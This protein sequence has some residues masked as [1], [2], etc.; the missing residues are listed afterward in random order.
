MEINGLPLHPLVVHAV[1]VLV[2]TTALVGLAYALVPRWRWLLRWPLLAVSVVAAGASVLAASSGQ[3]LVESRP[4]LEALV[5]QHRSYG[6]QL[7]NLA[8][9]YVAATALGAWV[10]GG[11]SALA[12]GAGARE[13]R[14]SALGWLA[15]TL[16]VAGGVAL[17]VVAFLAGESGARAVW[18][19]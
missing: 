15:V 2:P 7:R 13:T 1:V 12:S 8:L 9:A 11:T 6:Q 18:G 16:L 17:L 10:L 14:G 4:G 5:D 3:S 19:G